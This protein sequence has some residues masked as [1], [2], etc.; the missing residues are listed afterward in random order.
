MYLSI[1]YKNIEKV[2]IYR[3][4]NYEQDSRNKQHDCLARKQR[5]ATRGVAFLLLNLKIIILCH[6]FLFFFFVIF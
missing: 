3:G 4:T 2:E 5:N 1:D 6:V